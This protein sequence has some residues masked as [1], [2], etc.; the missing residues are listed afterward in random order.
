MEAAENRR[1]APG[2]AAHLPVPEHGRLDLYGTVDACVCCLDSV[3]YITDAAT[4][5]EAFRGSI[6][7]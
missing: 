6:P 7:F 1:P 4:L 2:P 3:N 5:K